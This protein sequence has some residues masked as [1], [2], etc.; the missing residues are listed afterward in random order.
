VIQALALGNGIARLGDA[1]LQGLTSF[2]DFALLVLR[3]LRAMGRRRPPVVETVRQLVAIGVRSTTLVVLTALFTGMVLSLQTAYALTRFGAQPYVGS[4]VGLSLL[5]ELGP[6]LAALMLAGRVG[7][8]VT[9]E[10]GAMRV[11]E[12]VDAIRVMGADPIQKLVLPR[13]VAATLALPLLTMFADVVGVLGGLVVAQLSYGISPHFFLRTVTNTA[14]VDDLVAGIGKTPFFGALI[15][16]VGCF[17]GLRTTGGTVG[18]GLATTRSVVTASIT[19]LI[20]DFFLT[21]VLL[22]L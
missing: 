17:T 2:G 5:R 8:G 9:A 18:V 4:V 6:V 19:V 20:A 3:T 10:L 13:V 22:S 15:A 21:K 7:A 16:W 11:T 12:Q 1:V 14:T